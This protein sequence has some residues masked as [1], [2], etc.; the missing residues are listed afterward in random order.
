M[1]RAL[2]ELERFAEDLERCCETIENPQNPPFFMSVDEFLWQ[3]GNEK[4]DQARR[5]AA[6]SLRSSLASS[7]VS[8]ENWDALR[9]NPRFE[10]SV[11][12]LK[13]VT[14][15]ASPSSRKQA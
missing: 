9:G 5:E 15:T 1:A 13:Q 12:R 14:S 8:N 10:T 11:K 3:N 4:T 2:D 6:A 7:I